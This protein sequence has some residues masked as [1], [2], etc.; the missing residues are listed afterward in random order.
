MKNECVHCSTSLDRDNRFLTDD[1]CVDC[2]DE[3]LSIEPEEALRRI[4]QVE[5]E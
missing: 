5:E 4:F 1:V 3:L 2:A